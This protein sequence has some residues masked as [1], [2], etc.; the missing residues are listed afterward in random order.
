MNPLISSLSFK[1]ST[2]SLVCDAAQGAVCA[3]P[4]LTQ[5]FPVTSSVT[6]TDAPI[7]TQSPMSR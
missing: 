1:A 7:R 5:T 2:W 6:F 4:E 3:N